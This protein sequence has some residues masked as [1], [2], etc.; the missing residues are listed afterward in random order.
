MN[1]LLQF[2]VR[3]GYTLVF[4]WYSS[5]RPGCRSLLRRCYLLRG[6][7]RVPTE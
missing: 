7:F 1:E 3:H 4:A 2:V 5:N 6:R